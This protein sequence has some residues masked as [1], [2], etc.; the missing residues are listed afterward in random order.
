MIKSFKKIKLYEI[1]KK[2]TIHV[3]L[4]ICFLSIALF[5]VLAVCYADLTTFAKFGFTFLDSLF[6]GKAFSFY[7]NAAEAGIAREGAVYDIG[8]YLVCG[9]WN[10]PLWIMD[11][12]IDINL[13]GIGA[14]IWYKLLLVLFMAICMIRMYDIGKLLGL[15]EKKSAFAVICFGTSLLAF[16]PVYVASQFDI[17]P[18]AFLLNALY[19]IFISDKNKMLIYIALALLTKPFSLLMLVTLVVLYE[20]N[21]L[22]IVLQVLVGTLP[23][24]LFKM[25]YAVVPWAVKSPA[26]HIMSSM[27]QFLGVQIPCG[28]GQISLFVAGYVALIAIAYLSNVFT[29]GKDHD[30]NL[31]YYFR[32]KTII[33]LFFMW[34]IFCIFARIYPY[35]T[36]YLAPFAIWIMFFSKDIKNAM[37]F[38][39]VFEI[40]LTLILIL[41]YSWV[42]GGEK[43]YAY[44]V[45][46]GIVKNILETTG[47]VTVAGMFRHFKID[48]FIPAISAVTVVCGVVIGI[49]A[50]KDSNLI[51]KAWDEK[52]KLNNDMTKLFNMQY[53]LRVFILVIW[54][55]L[56][57][58]TFVV[59]LLSYS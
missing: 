57:L 23:M 32:R 50:L 29:T 10:L 35:W 9:I 20:K 43:T 1:Y 37:L 4:I 34:L 33:F 5:H 48:M 42:Y 18:M 24:L 54:L 36:M 59:P 38:E 19:Y 39:L 13:V 22:K 51:Q 56:S 55:L 49:L 16:M 21:I 8:L 6:D 12:V 7:M 28:N 26:A 41:N 2:S 25:L 40:G 45:L 52:S 17:I 15:S 14:H 30:S 27:E 53:A 46:S 58:I 3:G 11:K 47:G 31:Q 44:T